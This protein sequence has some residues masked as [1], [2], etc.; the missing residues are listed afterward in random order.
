MW[1]TSSVENLWLLD[2]VGDQGFGFSGPLDRQR[3]GAGHWQTHVG[4]RPE[5][6]GDVMVSYVSRSPT[7]YQTGSRRFT[8]PRPD[9]SAPDRGWRP[10]GG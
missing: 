7:G 10:P 2:P 4:Y 5:T 8:A 3:E 1:D 9:D 6:G